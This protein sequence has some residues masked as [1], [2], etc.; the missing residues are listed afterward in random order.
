MCSSQNFIRKNRFPTP[1]L[2]N[3]LN[4][5]NIR[6]KNRQFRN[7][8]GWTSKIRIWHNGFTILEIRII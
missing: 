8:F 6:K 7:V 4:S 3:I 2:V 5:V 1:N